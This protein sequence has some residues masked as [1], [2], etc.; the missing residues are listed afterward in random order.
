MKKIFSNDIVDKISKTLVKI[1][2][3]LPRE[4][5]HSIENAYK[6][7]REKYSQKY[8]GII[9][10]NIKIAEKNKVPI[11]QDTGIIVVFVE[12]GLDVK[13]ITGKYR[14]LD[15][16]I[17]AGVEKGSKE[18][19]LRNSVV[20]PLNRNNTNKNSPAVIHYISKEKDKFKITL[21]SKGFGSENTSKI[22]MLNPSEGEKGIENF[23]I[24]TV[25][26]AGS[27][28]CPP[29]FVGVGIGGTFEKSAILSKYALTKIGNETSK[30][31]KWEKEIINKINK[32]KIGPGGFGGNITCL[33]LKIETYPTHIAGLPVAVNIC[34]WAHRI[35]SFEL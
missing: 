34:C 12:I 24:E 16:I 11:C 33:D 6:K 28:P 9:L 8:L 35:G 32:L 15:E 20:F 13:I 4:V 21:L 14:N 22:K 19:Y 18:G 27:L 3:S 30:Y 2:F 7:E 5:K 29:I 26:E 1:N 23:I 17:N 31:R 25:K 10:E